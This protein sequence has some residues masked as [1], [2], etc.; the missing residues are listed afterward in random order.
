[1]SVELRS[2]EALLDEGSRYA[3]RR[4]FAI[5]S[6]PDAGKTTLTEK[7]LLFG[8]AIREAGA[9]KGRKARRHATSDWMEIEKQRGISV[10]STVLQFDYMGCRLNLLDTPGH[11]DFSEDTYRTLAAA[12]SAVMLIDAAKGVEPQTIKLFEVCR[13]RG[14]PIF[15][16]INKLDRHGKDPFELMEE[17]ER[18]LGIR[19]CPVTWPI[20]MGPDFQGIYHRM[21][22][23]F[24]RFTTR[25]EDMTSLEVPDV[26]DPAL[27]EA[28]GEALWRKLKDDIE[29]LDVAGDPFDAEL[30]RQGK[31][32]PMYFGSA[33]ANFGVASF[34]ESFIRLAPAPG[35]RETLDGVVR[36][37]DPV[38]T[39]FVFKIQANMN[40]AHRD[41][42]AFV[43]ICSGKFAR[44]MTVTHVRTGKRLALTQP[45]Q[46]FGQ[47]R[48]T[49]DE[50]YAGD[51][52]GIHD[53]GL[54]R[55]GDTLAERGSVE[56]PPLPSFS[57]EHFARVSVPNAMKYK[58]F[59]KGIAELSEEGAVQVFRQANRTED[60]ILG[61]VGQLQFDV[62]VY[63]MK[64]EYGVDVEMIRLPYQFAR[65]LES[66][67]PVEHL[68]FDRYATLVV[69]DR[70]GRTVLLFQTEF[71]MQWLLDKNPNVRLHKTSFELDA[72]RGRP[73]G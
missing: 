9:V 51:I 70:D 27:A 1:M 37:D 28:L 58:Q 39:G 8:G 11:E 72:S 3:N 55:I 33:I 49:V 26:N 13:M 69:R 7:L 36:P 63:R 16:F 20:G 46:F 44:G 73:R 14:I 60:L 59:H 48:E 2:Q 62:F 66:D 18:V 4:T 64:H 52:I 23:R 67:E 42:V 50:A 43:R 53:P 15:T 21:K 41:R 45:Q 5:I 38:F 6:H 56:F 34:L 29:L 25:G 68:Q 17:I 65:W 61:A 32:T 71:A 12:D 10:T 47:E 31:L 22:G 57:P 19:S 24:E 54:F 40:P 35:P 30:V